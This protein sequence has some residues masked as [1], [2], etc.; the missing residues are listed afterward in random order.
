VEKLRRLE[1]TYWVPL[2]LSA[3]QFLTFLTSDLE[4]GDDV[5][6]MRSSGLRE[7]RGKD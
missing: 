5:S 3:S 2:F 6:P 7:K 4:G 1:V